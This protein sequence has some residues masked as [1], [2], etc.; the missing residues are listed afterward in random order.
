MSPPGSKKQ[1][2]PRKSSSGRKKKGGEKKRKRA[3]PSTTRKIGN[4]L[5]S[6]QNYTIVEKREANF[7]ATG[8]DEE[9][10]TD[11]AAFDAL[12]G[13]AVGNKDAF[14]V[15]VGT[16]DMEGDAEDDDADS[17]PNSVNDRTTTPRAKGSDGE[18]SADEDEGEE[19]FV[20]T[21]SP[22]SKRQKGPKITGIIDFS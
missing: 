18:D 9:V 12:C 19:E 3:T 21:V 4:I 11:T 15:P 20:P 6:T 13:L 5:D 14:T 8:Q 22:D 10:N 1:S 16:S 17:L 7:S 2:K